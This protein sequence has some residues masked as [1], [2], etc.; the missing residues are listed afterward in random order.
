MFLCPKNDNIFLGLR[1]ILQE[2]VGGCTLLQMSCKN[3]SLFLLFTFIPLFSFHLGWLLPTLEGCEEWAKEEEEEEVGDR[4]L[5]FSFLFFP[6]PY[7]W[8]PQPW[9]QLGRLHQELAETM[10]QG[11]EPHLFDCFLVEHYQWKSWY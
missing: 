9:Q 5:V 10:A 11:W 7:V 8:F 3:L 1:L 2:K 6:R 4:D